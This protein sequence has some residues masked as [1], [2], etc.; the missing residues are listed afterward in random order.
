MRPAILAPLRHRAF[1][2]L[3]GGQVVSDLGD[4]LDFLAL[5]TL[6]VYKWGLGAGALAALSVAIAL[7]WAF[8]API[9]GVWVDRW[10]RKPVMVTCDLARAVVV[11]GLVF[12]NS[13]PV[14]LALVF[15]KT[16]F[17][18]FFGPARRATIASTVP[19]DDL[20]PAN[21]L[22]QL[23]VQGTKVVGPALG[24]ILVALAGPRAAFVVD[25]LTFVVSALLI[26]QL[27]SAAAT[28]A[29]QAEEEQQGRSFRREF[30]EGFAYLVHRRTLRMA[31]GS[32]AAALFIIFIID[33]LGVLALKR[34]GVDAALFGLAVGSIGLGT[35]CGAILVGQWG[36]RFNPFQIMG[37]GQCVGGL[38]VAL[39]GVAVLL[40]ARGTGPGSILLYLVIG[41]SAAAVFVPYEYILQVETPQE[42][43]GRVFA[44]ANGVQ[45]LFQLGAP[46]LGAILAS[47]WGVGPVFTAAGGLLAL[48]GVGVLFLRPQV[49]TTPGAVDAGLTTSTA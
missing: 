34:L 43:M 23:S 9:A 12:A 2:L 36:K 26:M 17:S 8:V 10:P 15:V 42:M 41:F 44:T 19:Q 1:R 38:M 25:A 45:T 47:T 24:G 18:T 6:L 29:D 11:L 5:I 16:V 32:M 14:V 33:S 31:V 46:P 49:G 21:G 37:G 28:A 13:L 27:P 22:S 40:S 20:L 35:A 4:W 48:V 3:F 7:P 39:L 30:R